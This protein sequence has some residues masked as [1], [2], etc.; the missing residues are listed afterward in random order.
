MTTS[1]IAGIL[2]GAVV[3]FFLLFI[4]LLLALRLLAKNNSKQWTETQAFNKQTVELM[5]ERN[6]I[7]G[8]V[9]GHLKIL[10]DWAHNNWDRRA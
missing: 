2:I 4:V 7:D 6:R 9:A 5:C 1:F 3:G 10:A 8:Q